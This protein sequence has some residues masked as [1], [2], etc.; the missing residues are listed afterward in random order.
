MNIFDVIIV[1]SGPAGS[2]AAIH[3]AK[4]GY[5]VA[6]MDKEKLPRYKTCGGGITWRARK[7]FPVDIQS[8][9][10]CEF[11]TA[12]LYFTK[13]DLHFSVQRNQPI[14]S[15]VMRDRLD[16]LLTIEA[17]RLGAV[18]LQETTVK[19]LSVNGNVIINTDKG[20]FTAKMVIAADGAF[21]PVAKMAGWKESRHLIPALEYE[22][23]VDE[24]NFRRL[25]QNV[26]FDIDA[27]PSGYAWNFPKERHLSIGVASSQRGKMNLQEYYRQYLLRLGISHCISE[28]AH[29]YQIPLSP[30]NDGF[31][32]NQILL[33]GDAAGFAD[34][35][36]AEGISNAVLSGVLA[37]EACIESKLDSE[38][39]GQLY[40]QKL[41]ESLLPQLKLGRTLANIFYEQ[42]WL[43][44]PLF[45]R[46]GQRLS[47]ALTDVFMGERDYPHDALQ[48]AKRY[49]KELILD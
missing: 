11:H 26:R 40:Q 27:I 17:E 7:L 10:E 19:N 20:D 21:S 41:N 30:R 5:L 23:E 6:I 36:T 9:V 44:R 46:Y 39:T 18:V 15:M 28:E 24:D 14:I 38:K 2:V 1:G 45:K 16:Y 42:T 37:A 25:S 13:D 34:P 49:L 29:G 22:V 35:V 4:A 31:Y 12:D 48:R 32:K 3:L 8:V 47:E 43:R 33:T